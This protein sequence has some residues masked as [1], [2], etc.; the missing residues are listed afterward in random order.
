[1]Y[2]SPYTQHCSNTLRH[3]GTLPPKDAHQ[4]TNPPIFQ[5]GVASPLADILITHD[6]PLALLDENMQVNNRVLR[7]VEGVVAYETHCAC[8][9]AYTRWEGCTV[10][11]MGC[12]ADDV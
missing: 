1:V 10:D 8:L 6:S 11:Q 2:S 4:R 12:N 9:W 5:V 7:V 3:H